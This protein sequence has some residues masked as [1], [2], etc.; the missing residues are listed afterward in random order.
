MKLLLE[1]SFRGLY[2]F[3]KDKHHR[4][5]IGLVFR[6]GDKKRHQS[7][8]T[9]LYGHNWQLADAMS[10]IWQFKEIFADQS[11]RFN[12]SNPHPVI[13][14][15]GSNIGLSCLYYHLHYPNARIEAF[16]PDPVIGAL[17]A[18]NLAQLQHPGLTLHRQAVWTAHGQLDFYQ[19]DVDGGSLKSGAQATKVTVEA[20]DLLER[21]QAEA[22]IDFLKM[23]IEGAEA[24]LIPHIEPVMAKIQNL[25]IEYHSYPNE[26]QQMANILEI[27]EKHGFRYYLMTQNRRMQ[28]MVNQARTKAMDYQTNIYAYR[29]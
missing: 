10:F 5:F 27:L 17:A 16:E 20:I 8:Q 13:Y 29:A 26:P 25:F 7:F 11:Y 6:Y 21:L 14:D 3:F 22:S 23:D 2:Y 12:T 1:I 19:H 4:T 24:Q 9:R 18:Q 15:C 28:P